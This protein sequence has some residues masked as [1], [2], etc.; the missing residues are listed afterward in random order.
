MATIQELGLVEDAN[1]EGQGVTVKHVD[2]EERLD[3]VKTSKK[4]L[5]VQDGE[6]LRKVTLAKVQD[7]SLPDGV[8]PVE[9]EE[10][11]AVQVPL[12]EGLNTNTNY[13]GQGLKVK[14]L[15]HENALFELVR[16]S[17]KLV[18][19]RDAQGKVCRMFPKKLAEVVTE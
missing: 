19:Y 18:F 10:Q 1:Y 12:A 3:L 15:D 5:Y 2:V 4:V 6:K 11:V 17:E 8:Q 9:K 13:E 7:V 16:T 14:H